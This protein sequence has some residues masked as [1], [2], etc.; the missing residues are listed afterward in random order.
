M[1]DAG[2]IRIVSFQARRA[3]ELESLIARQGGTCLSAPAMREVPLEASPAAEALVQALQEQTIDALILLTGVGTKALQKSVSSRVTLEA[4]LD[5]LRS[6]TVVARGPKPVAVL[7]G[8]GLRPQ[9]TAASPHT[10]A[11]ILSALDT[12]MGDLSG[13]RLAVQEYGV[14]NARLYEALKARGADVLA[15]PVYRWEPPEDTGPLKEGIEAVI[16]RS[17]AAAL[18]SSANQVYTVFR[19][20]AEAGL[21]AAFAQ[22]LEG[23]VVGSVGPICSEALAAHSVR[24]DVEPTNPKMGP[25][26]RETLAA[27]RTRRVSAVS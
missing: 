14:A 20:A 13:K 15:V 5:L 25:L 22:G 10:W 18:F 21:A 8:W 7:K 16:E 24:V 19:F 1:T 27:V 6:T 17:V 4:F 11:Q 26:A 9:I 23:L 2:A 12:Q 3:T